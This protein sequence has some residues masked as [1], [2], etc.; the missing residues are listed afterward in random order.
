[1]KTLRIFLTFLFIGFLSFESSSQTLDEI[2]NKY[3]DAI[4]GRDNWNRIKSI[5]VESV[6]KTQGTEVQINTTQVNCKAMRQDISAMGMKGYSIVTDTSGWSFMP[7]QGQTKPEPIT[8]DMLREQRDELCIPDR[9][10]TYKDSKYTAEYLGTDDVEGVS[11][12]KIKIIKSEDSEKTYYLDP[13]SFLLVKQVNKVKINGQVFE[14]QI[15][16]SNYKKIDAG[17]LLPF[18]NTVG[19]NEITISKVTVNEDIDPSLF[20]PAK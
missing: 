9:L 4:G 10:L 18:T 6:L 2:I 7:F 19:G 17:I 13:E 12:H 11:C 16:M 14:N 8:A 20:V 3:A 5:K 1:M 15:I